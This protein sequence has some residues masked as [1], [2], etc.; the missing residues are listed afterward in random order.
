MPGCQRTAVSIHPT[1]ITQILHSGRQSFPQM[2]VNYML[3]LCITMFCVRTLC[4]L[5]HPTNLPSDC[6]QWT[7]C[8]I[9]SL[10]V[11]YHTGLQFN[12]A[13][14]IVSAVTFC[15]AIFSCCLTFKRCYLLNTDPTSLQYFSFTYHGTSRQPV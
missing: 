11:L 10:V 14:S 8:H 1:Q 2:A 4:S 15:H 7:V 12:S 3:H 5:A 9:L 6:L 13:Q